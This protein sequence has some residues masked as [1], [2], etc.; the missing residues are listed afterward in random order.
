MKEKIIKKVWERKAGKFK[1]KLVTI[2]SKSKI[3]K[4]D[5]VEIKKHG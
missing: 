5:L 2:P 4:G 1:Q 3:K